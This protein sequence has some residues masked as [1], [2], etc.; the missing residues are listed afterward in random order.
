MIFQIYNLQRTEKI[1][2]FNFLIV[3]IPP[4]E[5]V[6]SPLPSPNLQLLFLS[7]FF[8]FSKIFEC[9]IYFNHFILFYFNRN[10]I[11]IKYGNEEARIDLEGCEYVA[12]LRKKIHEEFGI[13]VPSTKL[14]LKWKDQELKAG[15][16]LNDI[17]DLQLATN[18]KDSN[19]QFL[20]VQLP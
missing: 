8:F 3:E 16:E 20:I 17:P 10:E 12:D 13:Q 11:W 6:Y 2:T 15:D 19:F 7:K 9:K 14:I 5:Q 4:F 18:R 1:Q